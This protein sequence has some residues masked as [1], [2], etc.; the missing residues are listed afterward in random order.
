[1]ADDRDIER[2]NCS[3]SQGERWSRLQDDLRLAARLRRKS[4]GAELV[5]NEQR[6]CELER[7]LSLGIPLDVVI[8]IGPRQND[9]QRALRVGGGKSRD[10]FCRTARM[11]SD[12]Q[13]ELLALPLRQHA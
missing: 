7:A 4:F 1:M 10:R 5:E 6:G 8:E 12:H 9:D 2:A 11:Q 13:V 3:P